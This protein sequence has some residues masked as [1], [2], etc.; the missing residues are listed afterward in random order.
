MV[1]ELLEGEARKTTMLR[2]SSPYLAPPLYIFLIRT[3][4][5]VLGIP[6]RRTQVGA[7]QGVETHLDPKNVIAFTSFGDSPNT[8]GR[9]LDASLDVSSQKERVVKLISRCQHRVG[10]W[11]LLGAGGSQLSFALGSFSFEQKTSSWKP[12][13]KQTNYKKRGVP[14]ETHALAPPSRRL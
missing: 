4:F 14:P 10:S 8:F 12:T 6:T 13:N 1:R 2:W 11:A 3:E 7:I 5:V 9:C